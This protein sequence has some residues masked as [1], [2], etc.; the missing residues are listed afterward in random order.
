MR[1]VPPLAIVLGLILLAT[2]NVAPHTVK[3]S[4][5]VAV[6]PEWLAAQ[7]LEKLNAE[8]ASLG[9]GQ[10]E[11]SD[12]ARVVATERVVDMAANNYFAHVSPSGR[13]VADLLTDHGIAYEWMGENIARSSYP[14]SQVI[15]V[16]HNALL[17]SP[18]HRD[19]MLHPVYGRVGIAVA[20]IGGMFYIAQVF[21]D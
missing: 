6:E 2:A 14:S 19:N 21:L 5:V 1:R 17:A 13:T 10:L 12:E 18:G 20:S 7:L 4:A 8:R 3:A 9:L 15:E 16:V 11:M